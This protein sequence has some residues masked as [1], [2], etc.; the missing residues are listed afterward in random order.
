[1]KKYMIFAISFIVLFSVFQVLSGMFLTSLYTPDI[2]DAWNMSDNLSQV[3]VMKGSSFF[4]ALLVPFLSA[5]IAY[6]ITER[7]AKINNENK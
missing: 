1:M 2:E 6:F 5:T 7:L 3:V 4:P